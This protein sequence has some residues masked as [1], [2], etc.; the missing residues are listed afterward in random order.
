MA[1]CVVVA[2]VF[3]LVVGLLHASLQKVWSERWKIF[4][5]EIASVRVKLKVGEQTSYGSEC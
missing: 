2:L 3:V 1:V 4:W 5:S